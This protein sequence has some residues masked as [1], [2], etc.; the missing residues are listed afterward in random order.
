MG[1][2]NP[3]HLKGRKK[4]GS[5]WFITINTNRTAAKLGEEKIQDFKHVVQELFSLPEN[6]A[7]I[8]VFR[9]DAR[10]KD[11]RPET[12]MNPLEALENYVCLPVSFEFCIE[13]TQKSGDGSI[14]IHGI[15][16]IHHF[17]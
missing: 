6:L 3:A 2:P 14:H 16:G 4:N 10:T 8:I 7:Q 12:N 11:K 9:S 13:R 5:G 17:H 15:L 1:K